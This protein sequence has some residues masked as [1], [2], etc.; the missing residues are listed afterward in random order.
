VNKLFAHP[1]LYPCGQFV[2]IIYGAFPLFKQRVVRGP[3]VVVTITE[4]SYEIRKI[5]LLASAVGKITWKV[6]L[7]TVLSAPKSSTATDLLPSVL[8]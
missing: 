1:V 7:L 6:L 5:A 2:V 3:L 4:C 8:L